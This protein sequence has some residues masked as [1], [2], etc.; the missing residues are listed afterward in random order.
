MTF[1][2]NLVST[3]SSAKFICCCW[4][5]RWC[6]CHVT[7]TPKCN[8][9]AKIGQIINCGL[10][11]LIVSVFPVLLTKYDTAQIWRCCQN[12]WYFYKT[13]LATLHMSTKRT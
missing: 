3:V 6:D 1:V 10:I 4:R 5:N 11:I 9:S 2:V 7:H 8:E 13:H 12:G